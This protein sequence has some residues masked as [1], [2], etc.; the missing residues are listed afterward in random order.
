MNLLYTRIRRTGLFFFAFS[1][2]FSF[3]KMHAQQSTITGAKTL[4]AHFRGKTKPLRDLA[5]M[6]ATNRNKRADRKANKPDFTPPNFINY[7]R[8]PRVVEDAL[9]I[10]MDPVRQDN[11]SRSA[12]QIPVE[13]NLIIEGINEATTQVGVPDTNGDV[14]PDHY[15]QILNAS[16]FQIFDR[17]GN[18]LTDPM[19]ANTIWSQIN[20][21]S[22]SDPLI[23][24]DEEAN[25]WLLTDL[26]NIDEVLYGVSETSDPMGAWNLYTLN[27]PGFADYPKYGIWPN[28]YIFTINEGQ[29][30]YPVYAL[31]RQQMLAGASTIDVQR[32]DIPGLNGGFPT[33]TPMD[34]NSP[35]PPPTDEVFVVRLNDDAWGNGNPNDL[36]EVWT[37][38][39]DW[40][41]PGN[42]S[43]SSLQLASAAFDT[44]GCS[45]GGGFGFECIPQPG[46]TQGI[47][48]IMTII[49]NNVKYWNFDTH[50]SAVLTFSVD[51]GGDIAGIRW[52]ELRRMPGGDW[53]IYQEGTY[54]PADGH[55]RFIPGIAIN[56]KGDIALAYSIAGEDK[57]PSL[58]Y[59]GRRASDPLGEMTVDEFEFATG[60]GVRT[61]TDRY[62]DYAHMTVDPVNGSFWFTSEYVLE[63]GFY[64]SKIVNY[65]L[66]RDTFD[67]A[68]TALD[69]P[70]D[71]PDLTNAEAVS[72]QVRN[73]GLAPATDIS[74]GYIFEN[75]TPVVEQAAIDTLF[76]DSIYAHT[77]IPTV[78]MSVVG[79]YSFKV[80]STF[81]EDQNIPNDTLRR[82]RSKLPRFDAGITDAQGLEGTLCDSTT[83]ATI[84]LA[85]FGT[86]T[87]TSVDI[88]YQLNGGAVQFINWS[89][90]LATDETEEV[91]IPLD[92]LVSGTNTIAVNTANPNGM[93]DEIPSNDTYSRDFQVL[94]GGV[95]VTLELLTDLFP[96]ETT[97]QLTDEAGAVL[98]TGG[99]YN[100]QLATLITEAWCLEDNACY[101]FTI[102]DSFGDGITAY[103]VDGGYE[104]FDA[105][106]NELASIL[107][108]AFGSE[109]SN[110]FCLQV[111]CNLEATFD[112]TNE[113]SAN[114]DDGA[115]MVT[116]TSGVAPFSY[117][118]NG[119]PA[120][121]NPLFD[122]LDGG[123]YTVLVTDA[124]GCEFEQVVTVE[125]LTSSFEI[126]KDYTITVFPNPSTNGAFWVQV[127]GLGGT[128]N[129][130]DLQ[131]VDAH[132]R[133]VVYETLAAVDGYHK[134]LISLADFPAGVY[135]LRFIHEKMNEMTKVVR[136]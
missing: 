88:E 131:V 92:P 6:P 83:V 132:G 85:N 19:S 95:G 38:N 14:S 15:I 39:I 67:I 57:E 125:T 30:V 46:T 109:E 11:L 21:A 121:S 81:A 33:C 134:G 108:V 133:T 87:L 122:G 112:V 69:N 31:N 111:P 56:G 3:G 52:M 55:H 70:Q 127:D 98:F 32:V 136:L 79:E 24:W 53:E 104:I 135:Y 84:I 116:V 96:E 76:P 40:V 107:N 75:G 72:I 64:G 20:Q 114:D 49:M 1:F 113:S 71:S 100:G 45:V 102:F 59:T 78:D 126:E 93:A 25:R 117:S 22:F 101:T 90:S 99:P 16:W 73:V 62:G 5:P 23:M 37:I 36:V 61:T 27:T 77:F 97:W 2:I 80:F 28:S 124:N 34:W 106:G 130:I 65:A 9:P 91:D 4:Q 123:D 119:G 128:L 68:P 54:A 44:D 10:G 47:D 50:E 12:M 118:L 129:Q 74:V 110:E 29:G 43:T 8:Q 60:E 41:N 66:T 86:E 82:V 103:G 63:D 89:G 17:E 48:G 7:R 13:P 94:L 51:A 115:I 18:A 35:S 58:R 26:A 120:Q 42:T 105:D